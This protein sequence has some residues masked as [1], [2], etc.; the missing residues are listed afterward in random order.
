MVLRLYK[1]YRDLE[2][3]LYIRT[4][5]YVSATLLTTRDR[6]MR[7]ARIDVSLLACA[8]RVCKASSSAEYVE[9]VVHYRLL[10]G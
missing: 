5:S 7:L 9:H 2:V 10:H 8:R 1:T 4:Y 6:Q 3:V